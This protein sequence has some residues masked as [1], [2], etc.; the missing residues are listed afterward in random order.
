MSTSFG[1][2]AQSYEIATIPIRYDGLD[3]EQ[4][5]I[6][7]MLLGE[8]IQGIGRVLATVGHFAV[9]G[10]Y[11]KQKQALDVK[12]YVCEPRAN[13]FSITAVLEFAK[14]QQLLQGGIGTIIGV[15]LAW[16]FNRSRNS[17]E[18]M[19]AIK[20]SLDKALLALAGQNQQ[21]VQPLLGTIERL[22]DSLQPSIRAAV[23]PVGR[24]CDAMKI[25]DAAPI[26]RVAA[27]SIRA[28]T[29]GELT[30]EKT[31]SIRISELD[32]ESATAKIRLEDGEALDDDSRIKGKITDPA[33]GQT[34]NPYVR[35]FSRREPLTVHAKAAV[36]DGVIETLYISNS[37]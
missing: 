36:R 20:D 7:L 16:L 24:S 23:A 22:A 26:D 4:H 31:W 13:C 10:Q 3:A 35:A 8:S 9:T 1:G 19:K 29:V 27:E 33:F 11:A 12:V 18:E 37:A 25:G 6:D 15:L 14:E 34:D 32:L 28:A 30:A 5:K 21:L 2:H 17:Q